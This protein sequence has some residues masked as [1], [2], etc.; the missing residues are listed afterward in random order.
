MLISETPVSTVEIGAGDAL[1][2]PGLVDPGGIRVSASLLSE[3]F[4]APERSRAP[5]LL[6]RTQIWMLCNLFYLSQKRRY[7]GILCNHL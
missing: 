6:I 3:K 4:G 1:G 2:T 7:I 5:N